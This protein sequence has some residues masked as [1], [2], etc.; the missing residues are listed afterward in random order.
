MLQ[1]LRIARGLPAEDPDDLEVKLAVFSE[2]LADVPPELIPEVFNRA[3]RGYTNIET[4]FGV[5]QLRAAWSD[6]QEEM[7]REMAKAETQIVLDE[8]KAMA[9]CEH[10]FVFT[11]RESC[12]PPMISGYNECRLCGRATPVL[13]RVIGGKAIAYLEAACKA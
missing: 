13:D 4:P 7:R 11:P 12:D 6:I 1:N 3:I 9:E 10:E 2:H 5:T 8:I